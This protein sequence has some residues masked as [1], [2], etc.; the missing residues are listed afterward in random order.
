MDWK[1]SYSI[2]L[3]EIDGQHKTLLALF[4]DITEAIA[5]DDS[6]S[7][8]HY[9]VVALRSFAEFHFRFEEAM[10]RFFG[11]PDAANESHCKAHRAFF[12][13]LDSIVRT[14]LRDEVK[15]DMVRFLFDWLTEH[16]LVS[17][18]EYAE[19]I[20]ANPKPVPSAAR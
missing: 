4:S 18:R 10:M 20:L 6:W 19:F 17:D 2:G 12:E 5:R 14:S 1:T 16:I 7:D 15:K 8:V 9:R 11:Y 13:R 3:E